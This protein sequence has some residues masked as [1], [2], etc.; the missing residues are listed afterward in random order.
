MNRVDR[1]AAIA[2][3][4]VLLI[5][6]GFGRFAFTALYPLMVDEG[7]LTVDGGSYAASANYAGYLAGSLALGF[8]PFRSSLRICMFGAAATVFC[9]ALLGLPL[10]E[11]AIIVV[12]GFAGIFSALA[13][14]GASH[15]LLHDRQYSGGAPIIFSGVV[16]G[17]VLSSEI[18][19]AGRALAAQ[20]AGIWMLLAAIALLLAITSYLMMRA[21]I[22]AGL[23]PA[24]AAAAPDKAPAE[25]LLSANSIIWIYGLAGLGYIIT[26]T[27]LPLLVSTALGWE[28]PVHIWAVF[29]LGGVP[30]CFLWHAWHMRFGT[31]RVL[32]ANLLVQAIGVALPAISDSPAS[33]LA[34]ALLVGGT[35]MGTVVIVFPAARRV[36]ET[37]RF[38]LFAVMTAAY[39]VGQIVGP[40]IANY[41]YLNWQSFDGA[42]VLAALALAI[43]AAGCLDR[44]AGRAVHPSGSRP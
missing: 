21:R 24:S 37:V 39:G 30:S 44:K 36:A 11:W 16:V 23:G 15:W 8:I 1:V 10:D 22:A 13:L 12:R 31:R 19:A 4:L 25:S 5:G 38:N 3:A 20:S 33:Y 2:A 35:F 42:L 32:M 40:L 28:E 27:Y 18:I 34:S 9:L 29:G 41:L 6:M 26:A 14:V 17:I 7:R 43:G